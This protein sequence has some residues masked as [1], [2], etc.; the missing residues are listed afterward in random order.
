[1]YLWS[2]YL[3]ELELFRWNKENTVW[4]GK[5]I[6]ILIL[7]WIR[8][9]HQD[10]QELFWRCVFSGVASNYQTFYAV[11]LE[12]FLG[13]FFIGVSFQMSPQRTWVW[14][15]IFTI[16]TFVIFFPCVYFQ[17]LTKIRC[18]WGFVTTLITFVLFFSR[19]HSHVSLHLGCF[20]NYNRIGR[21]CA[22]FL[23]REISNKSSNL[24]NSRT[25][26]I[27]RT[28]PQCVFSCGSSSCLH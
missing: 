21:S 19:M 3:L 28:F 26:H 23:H 17:M 15:N 7:I 16:G 5:V 22:T 1:M 10:I 13:R 2:Q 27:Y 12:A 11:R 8:K 18:L 25:C 14:A 9:F 4:A 6:D 24:R 20:R